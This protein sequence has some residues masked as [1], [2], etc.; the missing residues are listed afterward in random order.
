MPTSGPSTSAVV[1]VVTV[2][3]ATGLLLVAL[4]RVRHIVVLAVI[5]MFLAVGLD[6]AVRALGRL[7]LSRGKGVAVVLLGL[8]LFVVGF[9]ASVTPPLVRQTQS[10]ARQIPD[11][12]N[13]LSDRSSRL[14]DLNERYDLAKRLQDAVGSLPELAG[15][16]AGGVLGVVQSIAGTLF[17]L[18]TILILTTYFLL[19]LPKM[20]A[21]APRLLPASRRRR[22]EQLS[23]PVLSRVSGYIMGQLTVSLIAGTTALIALTIL[24][25]PYSL[26]LAMWVATAS[27][28]PM[29]GATLGAVVA[30]VVAFFTSVLTGVGA[31]V[32]FLV[33]QQLENYLI[34]P[35][36][37]RR[38]VDISPAAV[39]L[40]ALVGAALLGFVG[41]LLA[42]PTAASFKVLT[43]EVWIPRQD[44]A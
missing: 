25:V 27:L 36:V 6:P 23:Q 40:S 26:P 9:A 32:F 15:R 14:Y 12:V 13:D 44:A 2:V 19:D 11:Y 10:L 38:A 24:R 3:A 42:I 29:V 8:V 41:A 18:L 37:M 34:A 21:G 20:L 30:V 4:Y 43:Q 17:N 1:R 22:F 39:I 31:L 5:A 33:Y 16:S 35:R 7:R 28:I